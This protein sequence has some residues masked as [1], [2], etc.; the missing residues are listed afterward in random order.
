MKLTNDYV[1]NIHSGS[2]SRKIKRDFPEDYRKIASMDPL[3]SFKEKVYLYLNPTKNFKCKKCGTKTKVFR[4]SQGFTEHCSTK[5]RGRAPR[6]KI[7]QLPTVKESDVTLW[8]LKTTLFNI[9]KNPNYSK[10]QI[11]REFFDFYCYLE[12]NSTVKNFNEKL[13]LYLNNDH[14][15][16]CVVCGNNTIFDPGKFSYKQFCSKKCANNYNRK[17][18]TGGYNHKYFEQYPKEKN[19]PAYFYFIELS[20]EVRKSFLKI[21]ITCREFT[22]RKNEI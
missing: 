14:P 7:N 21:G 3:L 4:Y 22:Y 5:C 12:N 2:I 1:L 9:V 8:P 10:A 20:D 18:L 11:K 17:Y 19:K 16:Y 6:N 13:Y 15:K